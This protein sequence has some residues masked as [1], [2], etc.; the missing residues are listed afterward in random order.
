M[1]GHQ[2]YFGIKVIVPDQSNGNNGLRSTK[3][4]AARASAKLASR[5]SK[6]PRLYYEL[7]RTRYGKL[8]CQPF[9]IARAFPIGTVITGTAAQVYWKLRRFVALI[10][11]GKHGSPAAWPGL[12]L[13]SVCTGSHNGNIAMVIVKAPAGAIVGFMVGREFGGEYCSPMEETLARTRRCR[14]QTERRF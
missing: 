11:I 7:P 3:Y 12:V 5:N 10:R 9:V 13:A 6:Q 4:E 2:C 8:L 14:L 1:K